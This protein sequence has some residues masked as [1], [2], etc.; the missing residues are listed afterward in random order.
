MTLQEHLIWAQVQ[1]GQAL[2]RWNGNAR[3]WVVECPACGDLL[4]CA[5]GASR[6]MQSLEHHLLSSPPFGLEHR[7]QKIGARLTLTGEWYEVAEIFRPY[8][9]RYYHRVRLHTFQLALRRVRDGR[10][11]RT[12]ATTAGVVEPLARSQRREFGL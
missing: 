8:S 2:P 7:Q 12:S 6:L 11:F 4:Y 3:M 9:H 5:R 10:L 1:M